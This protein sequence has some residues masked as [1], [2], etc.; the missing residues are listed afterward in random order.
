MM[1]INNTFSSLLA[2]KGIQEKRRITVAEVARETGIDQRT[3]GKWAANTITRYDAPALE[4][5]CK[6]FE[7]QPGDLLVYIPET[8]Q[9]SEK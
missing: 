4:A 2:A 8:G 9:E 1:T 7:C 3:L 6:Y 5:L